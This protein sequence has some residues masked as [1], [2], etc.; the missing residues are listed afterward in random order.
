MHAEKKLLTISKSPWSRDTGRCFAQDHSGA[1][2]SE[3]IEGWSA[4]LSKIA[5]PPEFTLD[6]LKKKNLYDY[7]HLTS[8]D[9]CRDLGLMMLKVNF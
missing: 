3:F 7:M 5:K 9:L 4:F 1:S 2:A 6:I 8:W